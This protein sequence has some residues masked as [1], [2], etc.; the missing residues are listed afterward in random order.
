MGADIATFSKDG[1]NCLHF[2]AINDRKGIVEIL[3]RSGADPSIPNQGGILSVELSRH[4]AVKEL[5][6]RDRSTI[7]SPIVQT[8]MLLSDYIEQMNLGNSPQN[9]ADARAPAQST[10]AA[11]ANSSSDQTS[12]KSAVFNMADALDTPE[13]S[14]P[15]HALAPAPTTPLVVHQATAP[16]QLIRQFSAL[17]RLVF[18]HRINAVPVATAHNSLSLSRLCAAPPERTQDS[19]SRSSEKTPV[20]TRWSAWPA[21]RSPRTPQ[22]LTGALL[23]LFH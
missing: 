17:D 15:P 19:H 11:V 16:M 6:L 8:R 13:T 21:S 10:I 14:P 1:N 23:L 7:F 9:T 3:L 4:A 20:T 22:T 18:G 2:A 12:S 5:F